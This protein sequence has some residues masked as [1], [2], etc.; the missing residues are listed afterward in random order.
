MSNHLACATSPYLLQHRDNPV[1]WREWGEDAFAEAGRRD[2]PVLLSVGYAACHWCHVMAHE[3]FEDPEIAARMNRDFVNVKVDREE[4]PDIDQV[5]QHAL[6]A[7]GRHGGWPLT[8]FLTPAGEPFWG[9]TYF[10]REERHGM[11]GFARVLD[12]IAGLWAEDRSQILA[13]RD[14]LKGALD[15]LSEVAEPEA[16]PDDLA[17]RAARGLLSAFDRVNGGVGA[18]PKFPQPTFL[19]LWWRRGLEAGLDEPRAAAL[20]TLERMARGGIHDHVGGGFAR[21]STDAEWRVPHFEKML[22]DNALLLE[23]YAE[24]AA[25]TDRAVFLRAAEGIVAW[26]RRE[27]LVDGAFAASL[28]ADSEGVE[29]RF[30]V[31]SR[32]EIERLFGAEADA[33]ARTFD[34]RAEGNWEGTNVLNRLGDG[35]L[36]DRDHEARVAGWCTRLLDARARRVRP[37]RDDKVLAD[38]NGMAIAALARAG[39]LLA[40]PDW[41]RTAADAFEAVVAKLARD[42]ALAHAWHA[43]RRLELGFLDDLVHMARA[44]L[45]LHLATGATSYR[46]R[47]ETWIAAAERDFRDEEGCWR[48][49]PTEGLLPV[50]SRWLQDG[51]I[52]SP[53]GALATVSAQLFHVTGDIAHARRAQDVVD[54]YAGEIAKAPAAYASMM[55]AL[56]WL[57]ETTLLVVAGPEPAPLRAAAARALPGYT[58]FAETG[59]ALDLPPDHPAHGKGTVDGATALWICRDATCRAPVTAPA[60]VAGAL[61]G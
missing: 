29:G 48:P 32:A 22:Y 10:P 42:D 25:R 14:A 61:P 51:P 1:D 55:T 45:E 58:L 18:A 21:Y 7:L 28:D 34:V 49:G 50:R 9:G 12:T 43:G 30:Y 57:R 60:A 54:R 23:L 46:V 31:W 35:T 38:W 41:V 37:A 4:R 52:P 24:A 27:M 17:D 39:Q 8:M 53:I 6:A 5:Y 56:G 20:V 36:D 40:R 19:E 16:L 47:A 13:N 59:A 15:R 26:L 33:V 44:A 3:S 11:A 2:V